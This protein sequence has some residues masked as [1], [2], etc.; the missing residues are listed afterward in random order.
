MSQPGAMLYT[1]GFGSRPENVEI[2]TIQDRIPSLYDVNYPLGK[3]WIYPAGKACYILTTLTASQGSVTANWQ[4]LGSPTA[5]VQQM[6]GDTGT[7]IPASGS[8]GI[9]G[10]ANLTS[11][12]SGSTVT[13]DLD[14]SISGL[15]S[16]SSTGVTA[17]KLNVTAGANASIGQATLVL[18]T[19]TVTT[20]KVTT[21][22]IIFV[23]VSSLGT[24][25]APQA[26]LVGNIV[27]GVSFDITSAD[28]TDTSVVNWLIIN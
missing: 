1:Q 3:V 21:N 27:D 14:T 28:A 10:G 5:A 11:S 17:G 26:M 8:I 20:N 6:T 2:P 13:I 25:V 9:A 7:A 16:V 23:T 4:I 22:S 19:K 24:V 15:T 18:G 12:A